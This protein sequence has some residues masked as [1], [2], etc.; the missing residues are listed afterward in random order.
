MVPGVGK[1]DGF[2]IRNTVYTWPNAGVSEPLIPWG[3]WSVEYDMQADLNPTSDDPHVVHA[4]TGLKFPTTRINGCPHI[5]QSQRNEL[6]M[7]IR[8]CVAGAGQDPPI[9]CADDRDPP[10][11]VGERLFIVQGSSDT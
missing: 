1:V 2:K 5:M 3:R 6:E 11:G 7:A 10:K 8:L 9:R 4:P